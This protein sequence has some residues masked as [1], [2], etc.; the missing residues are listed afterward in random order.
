MDT[1]VIVAA[2][3]REPESRRASTLVTA[4]ETRKVT[5]Y[6]PPALAFEFLKVAALKMSGHGGR[7][8]HSRE[9]VESQVERFFALPLVP[10]GE[11][12]T[13]EIAWGYIRDRAV[14]PPDSWMLATAVY[15]DAELWLTHDHADGFVTAA[16]TLHPRVFTLTGDAARLL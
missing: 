7:A 14:F 15:R 12:F 1:S 13:R 4:V 6:A 5:A 8:R 2:Y 10:I 11:T 9:D 16:R 3:F